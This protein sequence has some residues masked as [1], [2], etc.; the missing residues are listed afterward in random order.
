MASAAL[1][2]RGLLPLL[3][4][5]VLFVLGTVA[6]YHRARIVAWFSAPRRRPLLTGCVLL[7]AVLA[8]FSWTGP[9]FTNAYDVRLAL[10]PEEVFRSVYDAL[11]QRTYLGPG[12]LLNVLLVV[13]AAYALLTAYWRPLHRGLGWFL[14]PL[15]RAS[16]YVFVVHV[17]LVLAAANVP[18][19]RQGDVW[20]NTAAYAVVLALLWLMVRT[21]FLF[22]LIPR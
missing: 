1:P 14:L 21:R 4:W 20:L 6:G 17:F 22:R 15:G 5:Q 16:L 7:A 19:L 11:F 8:V 13:V 12:R 18:A 10:L 3:V 2:V 9:Y